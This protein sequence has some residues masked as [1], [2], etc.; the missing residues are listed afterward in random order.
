[1]SDLYRNLKVRVLICAVSRREETI[2]PSGDFVL[3]TGDKINLT[4]SPY[5]L[6]QFFRHLGVFRGRATSVLIVGASKICYYLASELIEMGMSVK[7]IDRMS[8]AASVWEL[9][10]QGSGDCGRRSGQRTAPRGRTGTGGR[11]VAI[12]GIDEANILMAMTR[13]KQTSRL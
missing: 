8:S 1:M 10:L 7:I 11:F 13:A 6:E 4:S 9:L 2:I 5:E 3:R 12:T